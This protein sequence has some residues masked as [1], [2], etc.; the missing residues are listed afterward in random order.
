MTVKELQELLELLPDKDRHVWV[1]AQ[2]RQ[3]KMVLDGGCVTRGG[4]GYHVIAVD[5]ANSYDVEVQ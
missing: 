1:T 3:G 5:G 4:K 2:A